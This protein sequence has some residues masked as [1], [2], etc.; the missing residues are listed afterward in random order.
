MIPYHITKAFRHDGQFTPRIPEYR[1]EGEDK[2]TPRVSAAPT[3]EDCLT[4]IP[5]GGIN[6]L[7]RSMIENFM[8]HISIYMTHIVFLALQLSEI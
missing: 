6:Y 5:F 7:K 3:I 2:V 4:S 8:R 1:Y